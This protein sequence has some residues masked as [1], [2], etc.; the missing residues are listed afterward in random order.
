MCVCTEE[1]ELS[2]RYETRREGERRSARDTR[3]GGGGPDSARVLYRYRYH[4]RYRDVTNEQTQKLHYTAPLGIT[5]A[6]GKIEQTASSQS[7]HP[8]IISITS[9]AIKRKV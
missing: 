7:S 1:Q 3:H 5:V 4:D 8:T 6:G 2:R 9:P